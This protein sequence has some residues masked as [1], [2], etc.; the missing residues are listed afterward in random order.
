MRD[1]LIAV[2]LLVGLSPLSQA[3]DL[4]T[5]GDTWPV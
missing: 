4:G 1:S 3:K 5:W 2:F